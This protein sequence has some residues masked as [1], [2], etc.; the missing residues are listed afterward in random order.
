MTIKSDL[1][2]ILDLRH[3]NLWIPESGR[4]ERHI[5]R[6]HTNPDADKLNAELISSYGKLGEAVRKDFLMC[7]QAFTSKILNE[8][9][10]KPIEDL[11]EMAQNYYKSYMLR[12]C[13]IEVY[14]EISTEERDGLLEFFERYCMVNLYGWELQVG[15][16]T[17]LK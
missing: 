1:C 5:D 13:N 16:P 7:A 17:F 10:M 12:L 11:A 3:Y 14:Q 4:P 8:L 6:R 9:D 2:L 15:W